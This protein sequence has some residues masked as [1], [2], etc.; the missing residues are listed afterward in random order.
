VAVTY[1]DAL[2]DGAEDELVDAVTQTADRLTRR[3]GGRR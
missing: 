1:P 2:A 3:I